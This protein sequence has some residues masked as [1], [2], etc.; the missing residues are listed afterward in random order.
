MVCS[1]SIRN[2]SRR[3]KISLFFYTLIKKKANANIPNN[4]LPPLHSIILCLGEEEFTMTLVVPLK[5]ALKLTAY[6]A[7][8]RLIKVARVTLPVK[9]RKWTYLA[10]NTHAYQN[11]LVLGRGL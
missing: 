4:S 3:F 2:P 6:P 5:A 7:S 9:K 11:V 8:S 10:I 1:T